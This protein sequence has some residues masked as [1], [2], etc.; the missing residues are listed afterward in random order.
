MT[1]GRWRR[2]SSGS[3]RRSWARACMS[4]TT[5]CWTNWSASWGWL[6]RRRSRKE[7]HMVSVYGDVQAKDE[8][9]PPLG[10]EKHFNESMYFNFFDRGRG[11]GGFLRIGNRANE[12]YAEVTLCLYQ[13]DGTVLFNYR[14]P[15]IHDNDAFDAGGMRF[16]T[17][18]PLVRLRTAYEG[19][20]VY[21]TEPAQM[22]GPGKAF[23]ENP[24]RQVSIDL[25]HEGVAPVYGSSGA[26][27]EIQDPEKEFAKAH[28]EQHMHVT[29]TVAIDGKAVQIDGYG[30]RDHSWGPRYW[31]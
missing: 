9:T 18:E 17:L 15:E 8:Y 19:T 16:E 28:Y 2:A 24:H 30:L 21:L 1:S 29:G 23:R 31:Q 14:R 5:R 11:Q 27:R 6:S 26:G 3:R 13:P 12:S 7:F 20:A 25:A 10:P 4:A 22:A